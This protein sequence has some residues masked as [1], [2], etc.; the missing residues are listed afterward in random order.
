MCLLKLGYTKKTPSTIKNKHNIYYS[1][2]NNI[3]LEV[4]TNLYDDYIYRN[5]PNNLSSLNRDLHSIQ[6][7]DINM[8]EVK[9]LFEYLCCHAGTHAWKR[10]FWLV[11]I[12]LTLKNNGSIINDYL[13]EN[14]HPCIINSINLCNSLFDIRFSSSIDLD[15][16]KMRKLETL[17]KQ[18]IFL[19]LPHVCQINKIKKRVLERLILTKTNK[20]LRSKCRIILNDFFPNSVDFKTYNL[21]NYLHFLFYALKPYLLMKRK[22]R[23]LDLARYLKLFKIAVTPRNR[24]LKTKLSNG[25]IIYGYNRAGYGGRGIYL[26]K[27]NIEPEFKHLDSFLEKGDVFIDIGANSGIFTLKAAKIVNTAGLVFAFEPEIELLN[28]LNFSIKANNFSNVRIRNFCIGEKTSERTFWQN[29]NKP[30][31]YSFDKKSE[32]AKPFSIFTAKLDDITAW[33]NISKISYLKIDAE[34]AENE[35]LLGAK[36]CINRFRPIIQAEGL[37]CDINFPSE[38]YNAYLFKNGINTLYIPKEHKKNATALKLG[39]QIID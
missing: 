27:D 23:K 26:Y 29:D 21:P 3:Y 6:S 35:I 37:P 30:N 13:I 31:I 11:D 38:K 39:W 17:T 2:E 14:S 24:L 4:H 18:F 12:A 8:L 15:H 25:V 22:L 7:I 10:L 9:N 32:E 28:V 34:G 16:S 20:S 36:N 1:S 19:D 5:M 33:E